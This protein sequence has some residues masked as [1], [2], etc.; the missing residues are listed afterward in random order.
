MIIC[1]VFLIAVIINRNYKFA[2]AAERRKRRFTV[3]VNEEPAGGYT[4]PVARFF[5]ERNLIDVFVCGM[6]VVGILLLIAPEIFY[7]RDIYTS[8]Y[9]RSN[10]MFKFAFAAFIILSIA[11]SYTLCSG[12]FGL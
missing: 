1:T 6:T 2:T 11:M 5:G 10:T 3:S 9:L 8:G 12:C 4:N 7:V